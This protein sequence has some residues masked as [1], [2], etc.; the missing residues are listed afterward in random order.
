MAWLSIIFACSVDVL[1]IPIPPR[2]IASVQQEDIRRDV[3]ALESGVALDDWWEKRRHQFQVTEEKTKTQ[4]CLVSPGSQTGISYWIERKSES[5]AV[6]MAVL[7]SLVK[8]V[9]YIDS[10]RRYRFCLGRP[11]QQIQEQW[12]ISNISGKDLVFSDGVIHSNQNDIG[13][14]VQLDFRQIAENCRKILQQNSPELLV[15]STSK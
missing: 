5:V 8:A 6:D 13:A 3:W 12:Q 2:G 4:T 10:P 1:K 15:E 9:E 11:K 14:F 7:F